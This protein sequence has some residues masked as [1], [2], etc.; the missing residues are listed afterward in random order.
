MTTYETEEGVDIFL[1]TLYISFCEFLYPGGE[2]PVYYIYQIILP[3]STMESQ[4]L[5]QS[6]P[7]SQIH[8]K[9]V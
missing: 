2:L 8:T 6:S 5:S 4:Q 7:I 3:L 9:N 1:C